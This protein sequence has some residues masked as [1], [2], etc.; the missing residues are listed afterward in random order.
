MYTAQQIADYIV[1]SAH[2]SGS[3]ISNL[4]LQKI[5]YYVQGWHLAIFQ[6]PLFAERFQAWVHGP[7]IPELYHRYKKH[8]WRNIDEDVARPDLDA[9]TA[10]FLDEVL[11]EYGSKDALELEYLARREEPWLLARKGVPGDEPCTEFIDEEVM[12]NCYRRRLSEAEIDE[13]LRQAEEL[14][15]LLSQKVMS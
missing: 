10:D 4:K 9:A 8:S 11:D 12:K 3:F 7:V 15:G 13:F 1:W 6:C 2:E 14:G 5:L